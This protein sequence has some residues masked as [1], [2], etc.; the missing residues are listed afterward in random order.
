MAVTSRT[1]GHQLGKTGEQGL[2]G[3]GVLA[4]AGVVH[5]HLQRRSP[6]VLQHPGG[7]AVQA[8]A[9]FCRH[10]VEDGAPEVAVAEGAVATLGEDH[11][12]LE[13][14]QPCQRGQLG[15]ARKGGQVLDRELLAEDGGGHVHVALVRGELV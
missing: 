7:G 8:P 2:D 13:H 14:R 4:G 12:A 6:A 1:P 10:Q 15:A 11:P 3:R 5:P 9:R